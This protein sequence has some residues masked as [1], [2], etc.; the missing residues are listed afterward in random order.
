MDPDV[1]FIHVPNQQ[2]WLDEGLA[3]IN[4]LGLRGPLPESPKPA[5]SLRILA[6][7]D[8]TTF[9]WGVNDDGTYCAELE[10]LLHQAFPSR[11]LSVIN[12][13][14]GAYDLR[15][16]AALLRHFAPI[17]KPDIALVGLYWNDLPYEAMRPDDEHPVVRPDAE[18]I[19]V[20]AG[21]KPFHIA[22]QPSMLNRLLRRSRLLYVLRQTWLR[23]FSQSEAAT[24]LV[25]WEQA[26]LEGR[27]S[28]A[29]D[30]GW[31]DI[32][33]TLRDIQRQGQEGGF[34]V[35]V[36]IIPIRAQVEGQYPHAEYQTK[37]RALAEP[38]GMFVVDPLPFLLQQPDHAALFIPWD[39]MHLSAPGNAQI[40][41]AAF[42]VLRS[43]P[44][45]GAS[46]SN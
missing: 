18:P 46:Q 19:A 34:A 25:L 44:E 38:L 24:N 22:N 28:P 30:A 1:G 6:V 5:G 23:S 40:A 35:G 4:A 41:R 20:G 8:S 16:D 21:G 42:E 13:G 9:G 17:F 3:T 26:L 29:I 2:G 27:H 36:V 33:A 15:H 7:G 45:F 37:V 39:R 43:R 10:A 12:G 31:A 11:A 14:V 32:A